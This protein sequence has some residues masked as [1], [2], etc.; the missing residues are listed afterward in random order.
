MAGGWLPLSV[1]LVVDLKLSAAQLLLMGTSMEVATLLGEVPTGVVADVFSR[2]WSV[3][4]GGLLIF[5]AQVA[6]GVVDVWALYLVTQFVWGIGWTFLS[7]AEIAWVTDEVGSAEL[8]EPLLLRRGQ[9][10]F[11]AVIVGIIV[12]GGATLVVPLNV[13]VMFAGALG[14]AWTT[15]LAVVMKETGFTPTRTHRM[16]AFTRTLADGARF[17]WNHR[18]L[19]AFGLALLLGGMAAEAM[20]RLEVRR[21]EDLGLSE[22]ISPVLVLG[23]VMIGQSALG[24]FVLWRFGNRLEGRNVVLGFSVIL[25]SVGV[26]AFLLAHVPVLGFAAVMLVV[27]GGLLSATDPLVDTWTNALAPTNARST[28]HSFIGQTRSL[29]EI[30]GGVSLAFVASGATLPVAWTVAAGLFMCAAMVASTA[31]HHWDGAAARPD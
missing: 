21:L 18:S 19:R 27:Q 3:I 6:S 22:S 15:Y 12:F 5:G 23:A 9:L 28:V 10:E 13:S 24:G 25:A 1:R 11:A 31:R 26:V 14:L 30:V 20:D 16:K 4:V 7:G 8:V 29:G 2:K 17:T